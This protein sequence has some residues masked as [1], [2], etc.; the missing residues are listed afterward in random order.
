MNY[1][2]FFIRQIF[3]SIQLSCLC[4]DLYT[5][6]SNGFFR[7]RFPIVC[8]TN[9]WKKVYENGGRIDFPWVFRCLVVV[10]KSMMIVVPSLASRQQRSLKSFPFYLTTQQQFSQNSQNIQNILASYTPS[11]NSLRF[12]FISAFKWKRFHFSSIILEVSSYF[13]NNLKLFRQ[14]YLCNFF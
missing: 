8:P 3:W 12:L 11:W 10:G 7:H 13:L 4:S 14:L 1:V 2:I 6:G 5:P 9:Q